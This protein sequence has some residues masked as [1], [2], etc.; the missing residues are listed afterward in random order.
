MR[1]AFL[2]HLILASFVH[3]TAFTFGRNIGISKCKGSL[4]YSDCLERVVVTPSL[5]RKARTSSSSGT[6]LNVD[7]GNELATITALDRE[8]QLTSR[9]S[10]RPTGGAPGWTKLI[11]Q[12]D[13]EN[14]SDEDNEPKDEENFVYLLEP[15]TTPSLVVLFLGGAG[16]GQ[17]PHIAYSQLLS[18][19]SQTLN[20]AVIAA[21]YPLGLDHFQLSKRVSTLFRGALTQCEES[22]V[23]SPN[24]PKIYLGHSLGCKLFSISLAASGLGEDVQGVGFL[25][26]NNFGFSDTIG[27][28]KSFS[29]ETQMGDVGGFGVGGP[30]SVVLEKVFE[31]AEQAV[32]SFNFDFNPSPSDTAKI[33][34]MKYGEELQK[35][36][37]LFSFDDDDLDNSQDFIEA[38]QEGAGSDNLGAITISG[39]PGS[40]LTPVYLNITLE[41]FNLPLDAQEITGQLAGDFRGVSFGDKTKMEIAANEVCDWIMGKSPSREPSWKPQAGDRRKQLTGGIEIDEDTNDSEVD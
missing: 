3:T 28:V 32:S 14:N 24:L 15:S 4:H 27:M 38:C 11:L 9:S 34:S 17:Y 33:I 39:L 1:V 2:N 26:Y 12:I 37:R 22:G 29:K 25:S 7:I 31:F 30:Q 41:E 13:N 16:L 20:A 21:P 6:S 36:T 19:I 40:H 18:K 23:Y 8:W 5:T 35:K 10:N